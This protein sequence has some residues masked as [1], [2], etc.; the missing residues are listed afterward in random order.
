VSS[1]PLLEQG[2]SVA[3]ASVAVE[4]SISLP[5][6]VA[7]QLPR[8]NHVSIVSSSQDYLA[9]EIP[10]EQFE[11]TRVRV[12]AWPHPPQSVSTRGIPEGRFGIAVILLIYRK[13]KLGRN[14]LPEGG[15]RAG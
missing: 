5:S 1:A 7:G 10:I 6:R 8:V 2:Q 9:S 3:R 13:C 4:A 14:G 11:L 12:P 15:V